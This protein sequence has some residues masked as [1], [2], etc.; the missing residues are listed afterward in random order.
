MSVEGNGDARE[1]KKGDKHNGGVGEGR[2]REGKI[3]LPPDQVLSEQL[4]RES[5][6]LVL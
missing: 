4:L 3:N 5:L 2:G 6:S 1:R